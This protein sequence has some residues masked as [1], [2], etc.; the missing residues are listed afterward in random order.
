MKNLLK[1]MD[2]IFCRYLGLESEV[3]S[4]NTVEIKSGKLIISS[5]ESFKRHY[6]TQSWDEFSRYNLKQINQC[7][8]D[9]LG[10]AIGKVIAKNLIVSFE[11]VQIK[12]SK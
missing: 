2:K 4:P 10:V 8:K 1:K 11:E 12:E 5:T 3:V 9:K 7:N 6:Y